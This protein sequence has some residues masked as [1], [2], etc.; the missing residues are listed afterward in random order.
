MVRFVVI[1]SILFLCLIGVVVTGVLLSN[2]P[3]VATND[4]E[5]PVYQYQVLEPESPVAPG[6]YVVMDVES[7]EVLLAHESMTPR[8]TASVIK[9]LIAAVAL[10]SSYLDATTTITA[11]DVAAPEDFGKLAVGEVYTLR[12]LLFP[13]LLESSNDAGA[14]IER[15]WGEGLRPAIDAYVTKTLANGIVTV[16]DFN[17][18]SPKTTA[19]AQVLASI[20][21]YMAQEDSSALDMTTL[22]RYVGQHPLMNNSPFISDAYYRGG[23]HGYTPEAGKTAMVIY[24]E[25]FADGERQLIV[26]F[27]GADDSIEI[28]AAIKTQIRSNVSRVQLESIDSGILPE[29]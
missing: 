16:A 14:A 19:S 28:A 23:K 3:A 6:G 22:P 4:P 8:P 7:G 10:Q 27:M 15:T 2:T 24:D 20:L 17:G 5:T 11:S 26:T 13:Y 21:R 29:S 18:L 25:P 12:E 1:H 9:L